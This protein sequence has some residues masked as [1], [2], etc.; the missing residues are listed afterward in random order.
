MRIGY[1]EAR[2]HDGGGVRSG[3]ARPAD[4]VEASCYLRPDLYLEIVPM[5]KPEIEWNRCGCR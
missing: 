4:G 2:K 1:M 5:P 3:V